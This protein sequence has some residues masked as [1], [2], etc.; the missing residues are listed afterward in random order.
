VDLAG[1]AAIVSLFVAGLFEYNFGDTE[2]QL[3]MLDL[4]ALL[5]AMREI[6]PRADAP[7]DLLPA[8][9]IESDL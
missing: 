6:E 3:T 1:T 4:A 7:S 8:S 9:R 2:I 5:I